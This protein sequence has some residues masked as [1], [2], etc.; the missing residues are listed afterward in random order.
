MLHLIKLQ[1][2]TRKFEDGTLN[3][4]YNALGARGFLIG[5]DDTGKLIMSVIVFF[6]QKKKSHLWPGFKMPLSWN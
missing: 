4:N 5:D 1:N 2:F 6:F 3:K